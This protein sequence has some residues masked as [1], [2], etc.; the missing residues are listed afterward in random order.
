MKPFAAAC[1]NNKEVIAEVLEREL[2]DTS[3]VLEIGSGTGQ[4]AV[5]F[6]ECM[7]HLVW[8]TSDLVAN[9]AGIRAWV[10]EAA[11]TNVEPPLGLDVEDTEWPVNNVDAVFSANTLHIMSWHAVQCMFAGI[12][13]VLTDTGLLLVYGPFNYGGCYTSASNQRFDQWL[14][15]RDPASG[16]K[17]VDDLKRLA[18]AADLV[19]LRDHPMPANNRVLVWRKQVSCPA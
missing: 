7:P 11:L 16:I 4:H 9:H 19:L 1:D 5:H 3:R 18:A 13:R 10:D 6:A 8:M 2:V 14:R 12:G 15:S 17:D